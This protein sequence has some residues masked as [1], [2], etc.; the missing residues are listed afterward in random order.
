MLVLGIDTTE[1]LVNIALTENN[2]VL[3][4]ISDL[5]IKT[6]N[7]IL[8]LDKI[9][10]ENNKNVK[11][12]NLI[13]VIIG[14]GGYTSSRSGIV[15]AKTISQLLNINIIGFN[16]IELIIKTYKSNSIVSPVIDIKRN[17]IYT[18]IAKKLNS[19]QIDYL[20]K[21]CVLEIN[22]YIEL[23]NN[24]KYETIIINQTNKE[25]NFN[26]NLVILDNNFILKPEYINF[27]A[28]EEFKMG[29]KTTYKDIN[30][31]YIREAI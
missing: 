3:S 14:P 8:V 1:K 23:I 25:L 18:C 9:Y 31:F 19:F 16:K 2:K 4:S 26:N 17:E 22:E 27:Q 7:L 10:N 20:I 12:T 5:N 21:P 29:L 6:E 11:Q 13:A 28:V 30:P 15:L 24:F